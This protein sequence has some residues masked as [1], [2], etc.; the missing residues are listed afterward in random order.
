MPLV[1]LKHV[2][3][4]LVL[5]HP[6]RSFISSCVAEGPFYESYNFVVDYMLNESYMMC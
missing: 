6:L 4:G 1:I 3:V 2:Y 5:E